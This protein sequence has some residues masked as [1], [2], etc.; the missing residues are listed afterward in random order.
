MSPEK[1]KA[2]KKERKRKMRREKEQGGFPLKKDNLA[3]K[4]LALMTNNG[5]PPETYW[6]SCSVAKIRMKCIGHK[7]NT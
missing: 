5:I 6:N 2:L 3:R 4:S 7:F 1:E